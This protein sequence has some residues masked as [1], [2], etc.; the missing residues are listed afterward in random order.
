MK[1]VKMSTEE[2]KSK[3]KRNTIELYD[4]IHGMIH[5]DGV[6]KEILDHNFLNRLRRVRQLSLAYL[7]YPG[8]THTRFQHSVGV[9]GLVDKYFY[10]QSKL[11]N[12]DINDDETQEQIKIAKTYGLLHDI[13]HVSFSHDAE[14]VL[15]TV[16]RKEDIIYRQGKME[17]IM[18][19]TQDHKAFH[20]RFG[21]EI[22]NMIIQEI[23]QKHKD[24]DWLIDVKFQEHPLISF[25]IGLDRL[26]YLVRDSYYTGVM[27]GSID[28]EYILNNIFFE[29]DWKD[30]KNWKIK[31]DAKENVE[32]MLIARYMMFQKV[33]NH[34]KVIKAAAILQ[35]CLYRAFTEGQIDLGELVNDGDDVIL[36]KLG[37]KVNNEKVRRWGRDLIYRNLRGYKLRHAEETDSDEQEKIYEMRIDIWESDN[38]F[39]YVTKGKDARKEKKKMAELLDISMNEIEDSLIGKLIDIQ[40]KQRVY[41]FEK[42]D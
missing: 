30:E 22:A 42:S 4:S 8:A 28:S 32:S 20:E 26:D 18:N 31:S 6:Y 3:N 9:Y 39:I 10:I 14:E 34:E 36:W 2:F 17:I 19:R 13:G 24:K 23:I 1:R 15:A 38:Q 25:E 33:Y 35:K 11:R 29:N 41:I 5:F 40:S 16:N 7:L 12:I 37:Y 27:L 21:R